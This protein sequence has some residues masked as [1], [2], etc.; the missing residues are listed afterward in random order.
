MS[1]NLQLFL[2]LMMFSSVGVSAQTIQNLKTSEVAVL[3]Q[4]WHTETRNP[5]LD[6]DPFRAINDT[7]RNENNRVENKRENEARAKIGL[8]LEPPPALVSTAGMNSGGGTTNYVYEAKIKN[9]SLKDVKSIVWEYVFSDVQTKQEVGRLKFTSESKIR[10]GDTKNFT[11]RSP[12]PPTGTID[13]KYAG[14]TLKNQFTETVVIQK[15]EYAD[16]TIWTADAK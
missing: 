3:Q 2:L 10:S 16:G 15:I 13:A 14:K 12:S 9:N 1:R 4:K 11:M 8:P 5:A 7:V 6:E